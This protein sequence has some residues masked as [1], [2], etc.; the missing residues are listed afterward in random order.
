MPSMSATGVRFMRFVTS[1]TAQMEGTVVWEYSSTTTAPFLSSSTPTSFKPRSGRSVL[2]TRPVAHITSSTTRS[3]L[4]PSNETTSEPS[5]F[6]TIFVG[7]TPD[8]TRIPRLSRLFATVWR[9][10]SSNP[11]KGRSARYA[12]VVSVPNPW[13][14]P[15]NST[16]MYPPPTTKTRLGC[17]FSASASSEVMP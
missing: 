17:V 14:I 11:L 4:S 15:A 13:K 12:M 10:S 9:T 8:I 2:G 5:S 16:A 3:S 1:P 7:F 6:L